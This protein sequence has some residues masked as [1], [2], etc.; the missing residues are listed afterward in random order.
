VTLPWTWVEE[1]L[2]RAHNYWLATV[3]DD[4]SPYVRPVWCVWVDGGLLFTSSASSRKAANLTARPA[5]SVQLELVREVVVVAGTAGE[6]TPDALELAAYESKYRWLPPASQSWYR[7][8]PSGVYA[9]DE[10]TYPESATN[11][12]L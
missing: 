7:V 9:S 3:D 12:A 5:V 1:R 11:F 10:A 4:G 2:E 6:A 8:E